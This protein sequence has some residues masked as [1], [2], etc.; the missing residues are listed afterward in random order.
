MTIK[1]LHQ[2]ITEIDEANWRIRC[3][4]TDYPR[5]RQKAP[6]RTTSTRC[7]MPSKA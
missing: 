7:S 4:A 2:L 5:D 3:S 1:S 6:Q